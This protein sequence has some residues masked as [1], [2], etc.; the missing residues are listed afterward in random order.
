MKIRELYTDKSKWTQGANA[1]N[2]LGALCR[3]DLG[4][5]FCLMGAAT[6]CYGFHE[7]TNIL[8]R[9]NKALSGSVVDWNDAPE[10]TF[11][12]VKELVERLDV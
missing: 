10:R 11:E 7:S 2:E 3:F 9:I 8:L 4:T 12:D 1:R 6:K 5:C